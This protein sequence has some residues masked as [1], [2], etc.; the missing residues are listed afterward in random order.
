MVIMATEHNKNQRLK[1]PPNIALDCR[2]CGHEV[3]IS[4]LP[5]GDMRI[6]CPGCSIKRIFKDL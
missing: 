5:D 4:Y 6:I 2:V 3:I 1:L